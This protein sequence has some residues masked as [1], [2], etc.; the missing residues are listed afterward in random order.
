MSIITIL[1]FVK[2]TTVNFL[3]LQ[4]FSV[5]LSFINYL[6]LRKDIDLFYRKSY[7]VCNLFF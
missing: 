3:R 7:T 5:F 1:L 6:F 2:K 4:S